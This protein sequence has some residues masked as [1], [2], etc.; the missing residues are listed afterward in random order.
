VRA[1]EFA[2]YLR[3]FHHFLDSPPDRRDS[4]AVRPHT[5]AGKNEPDVV[6]I[7]TPSLQ[8]RPP[9]P[10]PLAPGTPVE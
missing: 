5:P 8:D 10:S 7:R 2:P 3:D 1:G 6:R 9:P 4:G